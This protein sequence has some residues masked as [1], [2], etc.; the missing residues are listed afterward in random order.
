MATNFNWKASWDKRCSKAWRPFGFLKRNVSK[1]V[2]NYMKLNAY[3]G[4]VVPVIANAA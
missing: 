1:L 4:Y 3:K 2:K